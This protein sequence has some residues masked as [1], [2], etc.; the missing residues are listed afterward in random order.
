L[1]VQDWLE[2]HL[3]ETVQE[4]LTDLEHVPSGLWLSWCPLVGG[5]PNDSNYP[6]FV[7]VK[8]AMGAELSSPKDRNEPVCAIHRWL[9]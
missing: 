8:T 1:V 7:A 3:L 5:G 6:V 4:G 2:G 9:G